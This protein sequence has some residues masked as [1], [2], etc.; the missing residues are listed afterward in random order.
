MCDKD[1]DLV[2]AKSKEAALRSYRTCN[3]NNM[4]Q[5]YSN[6]EFIA[7]QKLSKNEDL[8]IQKSDKGNSLVN[9]DKQDCVKKTLVIKRNLP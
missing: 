9:V 8:I 4:P 2:K 6:N 3:N 7:L 1:L 5:N